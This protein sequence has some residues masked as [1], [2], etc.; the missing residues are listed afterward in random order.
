MCTTACLHY[1]CVDGWSGWGAP[2]CLPLLSSR[3]IFLRMWEIYCWGDK[4]G[5][6]SFL[7]SKTDEV[8]EDGQRRTWPEYKWHKSFD[9]L[10]NTTSCLQ[11]FHWLIK[12]L[13]L[14]TGWFNGI[15]HNMRLTH[16]S[17]PGCRSK[18]SNCCLLCC[19][20]FGFCSGHECSV[21]RKVCEA[22]NPVI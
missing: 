19:D 14:I 6:Q 3:V 22:R 17:A 18:N 11:C 9:R 1:E 5:D 10:E 20:I 13:G 15:S 2:L 16:S 4:H 7:S 12:K 8:Y 21:S